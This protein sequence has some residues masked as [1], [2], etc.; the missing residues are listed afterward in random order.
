MDEYIRENYSSEE[1]RSILKYYYEKIDELGTLALRDDMTH[2]GNKAA[3]TA[4]ISGLRDTDAYGI[5]FMDVNNL[6]MI[7]DTYGHEAGDDY[8]KGCCD[9]LCDVY[10]HSPVFRIGGDEFAVILEG[11][12]YESREA[13]LQKLTDTFAKLWT[14]RENDPKHRFSASV[15]M[16]DSTAC[17]TVKETIQAADEAMYESKCRFKEKYGSYR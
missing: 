1:Y 12:D 14:A 10:T 11:R 3:Y 16:A 5:V 2:V 7:N 6:K 9:I 15:G 17:A 13:L 4:E 8:I